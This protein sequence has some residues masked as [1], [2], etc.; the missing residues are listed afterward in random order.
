V[1]GVAKT[2]FHYHGC[3]VASLIGEFVSD[4]GVFLFSRHLQTI[5]EG[6]FAVLNDEA[7]K[8]RRD[9]GDAIKQSKVLEQSTQQLTLENLKLRA[10]MAD[11]DVSDDQQRRI[12]EACKKFSGR[13]VYMRSYPN[14]PEAARLIAELKPALEPY[15]HV[16]DRTGELLSDSLVLGIKVM[17]GKHE[18]PFAE[19]MVRTLRIE[20]H[21]SVD[22]VSPLGSDMSLT[23]ILVGLKPVGLN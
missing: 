1:D 20:G 5:S 18:G 7:G 15:V 21:L 14:D 11:R 10:A 13:T 9:A 12:H 2:R 16:E 3:I 17:P 23:E 4:A 6:E 22:D 8:A 19:A